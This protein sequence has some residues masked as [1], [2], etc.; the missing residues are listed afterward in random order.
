MTLLYL[1]RLSRAIKRVR[2]TRRAYA[3][4]LGGL[5]AVA[6]SPALDQR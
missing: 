2:R 1:W 3:A 4:A 5:Y 6:R